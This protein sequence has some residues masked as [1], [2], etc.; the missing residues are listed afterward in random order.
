MTM[1]EDMLTAAA[2]AKGVLGDSADLVAGF[3]TGKLN[4]DGGFK[5]RTDRSDL[6]YTV[7][8]LEA[9]MALGRPIAT[10]QVLSYADQF[11]NGEALDLV[12]LACL[13]RCRADLSQGL[14]GSDRD[15]VIGHIQRHRSDNGGYNQSAG[16]THG[17]AYGAFLTL[18]LY[19]DLAEDVPDKGGVISS[20]G[21]LRRPDGSYTNDTVIKV[22]LTPATAAAVVVLHYL[23]QDVDNAT[24]EWLLGQCG[25]EGG[26]LAMPQAPMP[27]ILSTATALH[28]LSL[29]GAS[30][31]G[32]KQSCLDFVDSL[33]NPAGGFCANWADQ[34]MDCEYTYYALLALGSLS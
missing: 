4:P 14:S 8:G 17:S 29:T 11:G 9:L 2:R 7:F 21:A 24:T 27:D 5:G 31:E 23:G 34:T 18:G 1:R 19:H 22:G 28:A 15:G 26:F 20:I 6:Y 33:W 25:G 32:I 12:H 13:V 3:L 16:S 10:E 30:I